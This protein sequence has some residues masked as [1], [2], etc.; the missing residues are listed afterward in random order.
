MFF[1]I[2]YFLN[3]KII[4]NIFYINLNKYFNIINIINIFIK[5][6]KLIIYPCFFVIFT[7]VSF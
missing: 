5:K 7:I 2:Y 3:L 4:I 1:S 6:L